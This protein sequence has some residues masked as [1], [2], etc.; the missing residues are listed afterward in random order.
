MEVLD[1]KELLK[2]NDFTVWKRCFNKNG[3]LL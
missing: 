3:Q 1:N 2:D